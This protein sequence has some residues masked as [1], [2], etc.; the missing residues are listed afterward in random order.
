MRERKVTTKKNVVANVFR[1]FSGKTMHS[2]VTS[3]N[4]FPAANESQITVS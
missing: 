4:K 2:K 3:H 1:V